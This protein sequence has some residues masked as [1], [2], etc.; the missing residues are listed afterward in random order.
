MKFLLPWHAFKGGTSQQ[1]GTDSDL[2]S[3]GKQACVCV[4]VCVSV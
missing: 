1:G 3:E 4:C 2:T